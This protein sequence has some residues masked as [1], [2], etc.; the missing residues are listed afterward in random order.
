MTC[1]ERMRGLACSLSPE[2]VHD[3]HISISPDGVILGRWRM[4]YEELPI[5]EAVAPRVAGGIV[6][7]EVL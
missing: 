5:A 6:Y 4:V 7:E 1:K 2:I 3:I